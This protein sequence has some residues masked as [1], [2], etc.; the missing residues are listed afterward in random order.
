MDE[1]F[2]RELP[3]HDTRFVKRLEQVDADAEVLSGFIDS[4]IPASFLE[5]HPALRLIAARSTATDHIDLEACRTRGITVC[6]VP[7]YGDTTVAEH[8]FALLLALSRRLRETML[9]PTRGNFSYAAVRGF[10]LAGKTIGIIGAGHIG[11]RV[12]SLARAFRMEVLAFDVA[13]ADPEP[14]MQFVPLAEL[15]ARSHVVTLHTPLTPETHHIIN[16]ASL[17][18]CRRGVILLNTARGGLVQ[19]SALRAALDSGHVGGAGL[20]VLE[21]ERVMRA[22]ASQIIAS[23]IVRKLQEDGNTRESHDAERLAALQEVMLSDSILS[24][25]NVVFTPHVAFNST[26]AHERLLVTTVQNIR[27]FLADKPVNVA[28]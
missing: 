10:D 1:F 15:L 8:T 20:D 3:E 25:S 7:G 5:S 12:A 14:G 18:Q 27:A 24:R 23:E 22:P 2:S 9:T 19:T 21:D 16:E 11:R 6:H 17:A 28:V 26:E 13:P 4:T